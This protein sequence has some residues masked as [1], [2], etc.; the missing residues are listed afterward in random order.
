MQSHS[1]YLVYNRL[2]WWRPCNANSDDQIAFVRVRVMSE[3]HAAGGGG[4]GGGGGYDAQQL[5]LQRQLLQQSQ[6]QHLSPHNHGG[7]ATSATTRHTPSIDKGHHQQVSMMDQ[8]QSSSMDSSTSSCSPLQQQ[9]FT[10]NGDDSNNATSN[11]CPIPVLH[12]STQQ[13]HHSSTTSSRRGQLATKGGML[14]HSASEGTTLQATNNLSAD[15]S[16][17]GDDD[18]AGESQ[19]SDEDDDDDDDD[20]D[21]GSDDDDDDEDSDSASNDNDARASEDDGG[22]ST[23]QT[24][25]TSALSEYDFNPSAHGTDDTQSASPG[26]SPRNS[27][28][29]SLPSYHRYQPPLAGKPASYGSSQS[30]SPY[31]PYSQQQQQQVLLPNSSSSNGTTT[32]TTTTMTMAAGVGKGKGSAMRGTAR[33]VGTGMRGRPRKA[34]PIYHSQISGDKNAIKIRIKKSNMTAA[35][36]PTPNKKK[37]G[38][39]KKHKAS[40]TDASDPETNSK[41]SRVTFADSPDVPDPDSS[42]QEQSHWATNIPQDILFKIFEHVTV[43]DGSLPVLVRLCRVCKLWRTVALIPELWRRVDLTWVR[44]RQ[45]TDLRLLWL[46]QHRLGRVRDL[47]LGEWKVRDIQIAL[48]SIAEHCPELGGLNLSGWNGLNAENLKF[49]TSGQEF[50]RLERLDLSSVNSASAMN[51]QP[52][53]SLAQSMSGRLTHL[54]LAHNKLAGFTQIIASI[55]AHCPNLELLDI[56]NIRTYAHNS[57]LLHVERLQSGCPK[58]RV[59]RLTNSQIWL[60]QAT[61]A[62]QMASPG[63]VS[64]EELSLAGIEDDKTTT[65]RCVDDDGIE[66]IV[67]N[68][69]KLRLLDVR[70]CIRLSDSGLVRGVSAWDLEHLFL[71]GCNVTRSQHSGLELVVQK[72]SHSLREVDLA[73]STATESLD[74]AVM[75]L[76]EK[77]EESPLKVLNLCGSSVSLPPVKAVL[78]HCPHLQSI[79]L[80]SCRALP[81]G[82]KR[83]YP[84]LSAVT[85]LRQ[86]LQDK[87]A[88]VDNTTASEMEEGA[89][90]TTPDANNSVGTTG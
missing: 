78:T 43:I 49:L 75:A 29:N 9:H 65:A 57:A 79:N 47:N 10:T 3:H 69:T 86:S 6:Y 25:K 40:D 66:R 84:T 13:Y 14:V 61:R 76:A 67:K 80:Q 52:L 28:A 54:V 35:Q 18:T 56:S 39:R 1:A 30:N 88:V 15:A 48:E 24:D 31:S 58:L 27:P 72:W 53:V 89:G 68:S 45:R 77:G 22:M 17:T 7:G 50:E 90:L 2:T 4:A 71:S 38:R 70:G 82:I 12:I 21:D 23:P 60:A 63:F 85:E 62:D 11:P 55:A 26:P 34:V 87:P 16:A 59:L 37:S 51:A 44:E 32:T 36:G 19:I 42:S 33:K 5:Q 83:L 64:L 81:R 41:K 73:W 46:I 20:D 8:H 74:A